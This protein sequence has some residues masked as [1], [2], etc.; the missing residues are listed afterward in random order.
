MLAD[1]QKIQ[2]HM[3]VFFTKFGHNQLDP[4]AGQT[5]PENLIIMNDPDFVADM[6]LPVFDLD[7]LLAATSQA[8]NK[9]SS[10]LSPLESGGSS[11]PRFDLRLELGHSDS[12][13]SQDSPFG[14][15]GLSSSQKPD[16]GHVH[17]HQD[18]EFAGAGNWG[19]EIDENGNIIE[20]DDIAVAADEP[21][22]PPL[23][24]MDDG[25]ADEANADQP[26]Q[27][28]V[29]DQGDIII[30]D[31]ELRPDAKA[32]PER[33][34]RDGHDPFIDDDQQESPARVPLRRRRKARVLQADEE[35]QI[36]R[37]IIKDWQYNY[38]QN[39]GVKKARP[40]TGAARSKANAMLLTFGLGLGN[41]GQNLGI[42]GMVHPL[43]LHFSG[44]SLFTAL[45]GLDVPEQSRGTRRKASESIE[46]DE[47]QNER[48][49]RPRLDDDD[50]NQQGR[51][52][53]GNDVVIF[54]DGQPIVNS[55]PEVGREAQAAM[56]DH[57]SSA[58]RM[59]WNRGSSVR[60]SAQKGRIP[61][62]PL[63]NRGSIQDVL[64]HSDDN[65]MD[66]GFDIG[67]IHSDDF[68]VREP[69][70]DTQA[71]GDESKS[72]ALDLEGQ[73]F[74]SFMEAAIREDGERRLDE[75]YDVNRR[76]VAFED[77]FVPRDTPRAT[78]AQ[79]FYHT[80]CL[81]TKGRME[82]LQDGEA[83]EP[84]GEIWIG[85]KLI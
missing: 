60:G 58:L 55:S 44:D 49:V 43:A 11:G 13:G 1:L 59:P 36:S 48:R 16:D 6:R 7:A 62:S 70:G 47:E 31:D 79:A 12:P 17:I 65:S 83:H 52:Q 19:M 26:A 75:D 25:N 64:H 78:A 33:Q 23:P 53:Q 68:P 71:Q 20:L 27:P 29:D 30:M 56:S 73:S 14:I 81:A 82:V 67:G 38:L 9:T 57:L 45:T 41:I 42:P 22:L 61:S 2:A 21:D 51:G 32:F 4:E 50:A 5:R 85:A 35:T 18:D 46:D 34:L 80:L 37:N 3:H 63:G 66:L 69:R 84:F 74:F 39:C 72:P 54:D 10:Q 8:T 28:N 77:L 76:W 24:K 40:T 15:R